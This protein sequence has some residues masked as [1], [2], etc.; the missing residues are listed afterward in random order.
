[1][2]IIKHFN[3]KK[4]D[5]LIILSLKDK[6][7]DD[8][9]KKLPKKYKSCFILDEDLDDRVKTF[10]ST[11]EEEL[12]EI[13]PTEGK[14]KSGDFGEIL[15]YYLFKE[16]YK[17]KKINGPKKWRWKESQNVSAPYSDVILFSIINQA[18][19][20]N[21]DL[22]ISAES[23]MKA[24]PNKDSHPIQNAIDGAEKDYVSR[25]ANSLCWIKKKYKDESRK[26]NAKKDELI[27]HVK[28]IN[29]FIHSEKPKYG[30]YIK[31]VKAIAFVDEKFLA[32]EII[33][34]INIPN[35]KGMNLEVYVV[36]IKDLQKMYETVYI[37]IFKL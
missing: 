19:P 2:E 9:F 35:H 26:T 11:K 10:S 12:A 25:I 34:P 32:T 7:W 13:L 14:I 1:M 8:F 33:K 29:R 27:Q 5:K 21:A 4:H 15:A 36:G 3:T 30:E 16:N 6:E 18:A 20:S 23:K 24:T 17:D 28:N 22:L 37:E 31:I